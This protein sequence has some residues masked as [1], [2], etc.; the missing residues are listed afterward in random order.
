MERE[1]DF[2]IFILD[3]PE[4]TARLFMF[5]L[6]GEKNNA[7]SLRTHRGNLKKKSRV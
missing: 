6:R 2:V 4:T 7:D 3:I 5:G 1:E